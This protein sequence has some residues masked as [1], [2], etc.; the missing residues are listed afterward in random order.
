MEGVRGGV[1]GGG[2]GHDWGLSVT[3]CSQSRNPYSN[4]GRRGG[5][6]MAE[7]ALLVG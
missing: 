2:V 7:S 5:N 4:G 1:E 3:D 6:L